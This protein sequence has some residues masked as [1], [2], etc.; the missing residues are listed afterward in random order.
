MKIASLHKYTGPLACGRKTSSPVRA[1]AKLAVVAAALFASVHLANA[2]EVD[3]LL[4]SVADPAS[5]PNDNYWNVIEFQNVGYPS[6]N[7]VL[8]ICGHNTGI[9]VAPYGEEYD[10]K[11][12]APR[13]V[14]APS[15]SK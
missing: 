1:L 7:N 8:D 4:T 9:N 3:V 14:V 15:R 13:M 6:I 2:T 12:T 5:P 11:P 10:G